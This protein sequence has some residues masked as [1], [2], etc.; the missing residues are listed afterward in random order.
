MRRRPPQ[1]GTVGSAIADGLHMTI[2]CGRLGCYHSANVDLEAM[3]AK[4]GADYPVADFVGRSACSKCG[5]RWLKI[6]IRVAP[7]NT[8]G[9]R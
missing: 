8:G 7:I 4:L 3:R 1:V 6:S 5:A 9:F 2:Y